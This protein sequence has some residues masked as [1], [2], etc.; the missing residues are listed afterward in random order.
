[1]NMSEKDIEEI[2]YSGPIIRGLDDNDI[3]AIMRDLRGKLLD[4]VHPSR[5]SGEVR[6]ILYF[7]SRVAF[8]AQYVSN[9]VSI[10]LFGEREDINHVKS[11]FAET[12]KRLFKQELVLL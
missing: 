10:R 7:H 3:T 12:Y 2:I 8:N 5:G 4:V 6:E 1:M 11:E 9:S